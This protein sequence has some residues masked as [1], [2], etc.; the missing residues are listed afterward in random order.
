MGRTPQPR[1]VH[2]DPGP[3]GGLGRPQRL[4][5]VD[6]AALGPSGSQKQAVKGFGL[7]V[8]W[9]GQPNNPKANWCGLG[10]KNKNLKSFRET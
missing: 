7:G 4:A 6:A 5:G 10:A 8:V 2:P 3:T 9:R 1:L